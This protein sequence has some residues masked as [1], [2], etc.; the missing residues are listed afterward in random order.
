MCEIEIEIEIEIETERGSAP[1][2]LPAPPHTPTHPNFT[3]ITFLVNFPILW[4]FM[5]DIFK[6]GSGYSFTMEILAPGTDIRYRESITSAVDLAILPKAIGGDAVSVDEETGEVDER[7]CLG[8]K[9]PTIKSF[10]QG[11]GEGRY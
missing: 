1:P 5:I 2:P 6:A 3:G 9:F 11:I 7:C 10:V 4:K 8:V